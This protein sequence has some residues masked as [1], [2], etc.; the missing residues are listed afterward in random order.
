MLLSEEQA[1][2]GETTISIETTGAVDDDVFSYVQENMGKF[3]KFIR[4]LSKE[5]QELLL[6]YY[7]L[8]KPQNILADIFDNTQTAC[9][10]SIR[11]AM[12]KIGT[13]MLF[14]D[15]SLEMIS[16]ILKKARLEDGLISV[17][18]NPVP[19]S[20]CIKAYEDCRNFQKVATHYDLHRPQVR[21]A[22]SQ[23]SK[24]L[25]ESKDGNEEALGAFIH[26]LIEKASAAGQ[27]L[28]KRQLS[29]LGHKYR[30]DPPILGQFRVKLED[31]FFDHL[32]V[33]RANR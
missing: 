11:M 28:S 16:A 3:L 13:A 32:F 33:S 21:R 5:D 17:H 8:G 29:K 30:Q 23:A 20:C 19:L 2:A 7:L 25:L 9:S 10:A 1:L 31:P 24:K 22:M 12:K 4:F 26:G 15:P 18:N 27:G 6:S 14:G